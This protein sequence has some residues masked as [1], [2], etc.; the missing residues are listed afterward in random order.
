MLASLSFWAA[1]T[2]VLLAD[3]SFQIRGRHKLEP[4]EFIK[5]QRNF[6]SHCNY[7]PEPIPGGERRASRSRVGQ[8]DARH[9]SFL[10]DRK[11][12]IVE[13]NSH[14]RFPHL[15]SVLSIHISRHQMSVCIVFA[16]L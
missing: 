15:A 12:L 16:S 2:R 13:L 9:M 6:Q 4:T 14:Y 10:H 8:P 3:S 11:S 1:Q 7:V 5:T